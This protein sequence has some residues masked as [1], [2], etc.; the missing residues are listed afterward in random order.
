MDTY[1]LHLPADG[2]PGERE[3][4]E[5]A[6]LVKDGFSWGAFVF[7]AVWFFMHRLWLAGLG[8]LLVILLFNL[9]LAAA[10]VRPGTAL[11][12][13][14][15]LSILIGLEA[16]SL[17]RWTYARRGWPAVDVV[18]AVDREE[19][20]VKAFAR[21]L[22]R[23]DGPRGARAPSAMPAYRGPEPVIGLFPDPETRR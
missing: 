2:R 14:V 22:R 1:T 10:G 20:E 11:L 17:T 3:A 13:Q 7:S 12:A 15:L 18:T 16:S 19:A 23:A 6:E 9:G 4:L 8:V 5:K 21:W